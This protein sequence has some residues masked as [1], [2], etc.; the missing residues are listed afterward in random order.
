MHRSSPRRQSRPNRVVA[1]PTPAA[2]AVAPRFSELTLSN[3]VRLH[4]LE[5]GNLHGSPV[6]LLHGL[7]D[8]WFSFSRVLPDLSSEY[9]VF[10]LD[11]RG[12]GDSDRPGEGYTPR[13]M[14]ADVVGFLDALR[15]QRATLVGHS[16][17]SFVAQQA[18]RLAPARVAGLVLIGSATTA[19]NQVLLELEQALAQLPAVVPEDFAREFQSSTIHHPVPEAFLDRVVAECRK[20]PARVWQGSLAGLIGSERFPGLDGWSIPALLIW[21]ERDAIF[22]RAEQE[23]LVGTLRIASLRVYRETGHAPHWERPKQVVRDL[24]RFLRS[25]SS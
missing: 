3:G 1:R 24:E 25:G 17:G 20:A 19:R 18:A 10:A 13:E 7:S 16:M 8:S 15:I 6:I 4:Y 22:S 9:R 11:L 21:G 14:A 12:H 2:A 5:Q 23:A